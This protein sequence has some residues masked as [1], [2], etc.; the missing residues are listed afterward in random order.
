M[1]DHL[2]WEVRELRFTNDRENAT[3]STSG[4]FEIP[5]LVTSSGITSSS[6]VVFGNTVNNGSNICCLTLV[7]TVNEKSCT[8]FK[9]YGEKT[10]TNMY[11][12][13]N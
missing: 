3:L 7:E 1:N 6:I 13:D 11:I 10:R 5:N 9:I 2:I 8:I 4:I 12:Q